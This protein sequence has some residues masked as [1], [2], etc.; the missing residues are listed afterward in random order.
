MERYCRECGAPIAGR[1]DKRFCSDACRIAWHN[2]RYYKQLRPTAA[3]NQKLARNRRILEA[4]CA[5]GVHSVRLS[6]RRMEGY[7]RRYFTSVV[8]LPLRLARYRVYEYSFYILAGRIY[9]LTR[10]DA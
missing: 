7:D 9:H 5:A 2:H 8:R 10:L 3:V 1:P 4:V 6:D